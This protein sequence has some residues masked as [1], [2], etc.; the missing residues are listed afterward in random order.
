M[1]DNSHRAPMLD[2]VR[3]QLEM[4]LAAHGV[5]RVAKDAGCFTARVE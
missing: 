3:Q 2:E 5:I 1:V 4:T